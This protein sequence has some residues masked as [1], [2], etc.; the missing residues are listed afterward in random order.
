MLSVQQHSEDGKSFKIRGI[1]RADLPLGDVPAE[2]RLLSNAQINDALR[3][4]QH[5]MSR[6]PG[7]GKD[8]Y[9]LGRDA[10]AHLLGHLVAQANELRALKKVPS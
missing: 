2:G 3:L 7:V 8:D 1:S 4:A 5:A 9:E 6:R 10:L